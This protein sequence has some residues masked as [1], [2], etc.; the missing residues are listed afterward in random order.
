[1][2]SRSRA[3]RP[4]VEDDNMQ[5]RANAAQRDGGVKLRLLADE[6]Y[7]DVGVVGDERRLCRR[8]GGIER[9]ADA[10]QVKD[11]EIGQRPCHC[12]IGENTDAFLHF[13]AQPQ[14]PGGNAINTSGG[15]PK[16]AATRRWAT[17]GEKLCD[18][19][20]G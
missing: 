13:D 12:V 11:S 1:M 15:L 10:T 14:Q 7:T 16:S 6:Q 18:R 5:L 19:L 8:I 4:L 2:R 9:Y 3:D 20:G 17:I